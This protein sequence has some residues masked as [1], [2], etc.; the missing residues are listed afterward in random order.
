MKVKINCS[1]CD[2]TGVYTNSG[3]SGCFLMCNLCEGNGYVEADK[4]IERK[5]LPDKVKFILVNDKKIPV[6]QW[7]KEQTQ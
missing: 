1:R 6:E 3:W 5:Q 2:G 4:F 7:L